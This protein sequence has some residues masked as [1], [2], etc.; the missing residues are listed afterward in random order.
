M[1]TAVISA[2]DK[3]PMVRSFTTG[4]MHKVIKMGWFK[5]QLFT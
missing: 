5:G 1:I 2:T 3:F 4:P